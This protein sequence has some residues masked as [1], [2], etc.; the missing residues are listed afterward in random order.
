VQFN[1]LL[2]HG[3]FTVA[4]DG[5]FA[6]NPE[7]IKAGVEGLTRE[8]MTLQAEGSYEKAKGLTARLGVVRPEVQRA[9]DK[10]SDIPIDIE[11]KFTTAEQLVREFP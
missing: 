9:L 6:V 5:T 4:A 10:M 1:Y 11:P 2:D 3:G 8:I 7:K